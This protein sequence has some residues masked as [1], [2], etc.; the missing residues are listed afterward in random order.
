MT[1]TEWAQGSALTLLLIALALLVGLTVHKLI[2]NRRAA[3][4]EVRWAAYVAALGELAYRGGYP[5]QMLQ[6]WVSDSVFREVAIEY[7]KFLEGKH[8]DRVLRFAYEVGIGH[9]L[10]RDLSKRRARVRSAAAEGLAQLGHDASVPYLLPALQDRS[11]SVRINAAH[12]LSRIG[13]EE[14]IPAVLAALID[15]LEWAQ[16]RMADA[17]IEFG[18]P[19]VLPIT[20]VVGDT[21][22][23]SPVRRLLIQVLGEIGDDQAEP[24]LLA[25]LSSDD[26][27]IRIRS[28]AALSTAGSPPSVDH[29]IQA[30]Y[31]PDWRV[32]AQAANALAIRMDP[33]AIPSLTLALRD[34]GWWVRQNAATALMQIPGGKKTLFAALQDPDEFARDVAIE[35]LM[36]SQ[37]PVPDTPEGVAEEIE[38]LDESGRSP[39]T[40]N[41]ALVSTASKHLSPKHSAPHEKTPTGRHRAPGVRDRSKGRHRP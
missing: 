25:G 31:D 36:G 21:S 19:A 40:S 11:E 38:K 33:L 28:V 23:P 16:N 37:L 6:G 22:V 3:F 5:Q 10:H 14:S 8:R 4:R 35:H 29:L 12:A 15:D 24:V 2:R 18:S 27:E 9:K 20:E 41:S 34:S 32:R 26:L 7:L 1:P 17:L 13:D 30:M 39:T